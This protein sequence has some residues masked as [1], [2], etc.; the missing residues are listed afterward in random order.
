MGTAPGRSLTNRARHNELSNRQWNRDG[1][2]EI[3]PVRENTN[4]PLLPCANRNRDVAGAYPP[5][6]VGDQSEK[7]VPQE[8]FYTTNIT[9]GRNAFDSAAKT[10]VADVVAGS[11]V[12]FRCSEKNT[13]S[14]GSFWHPG[15]AMI[16]LSRAPDDD[17]KKYRGDGDWFKVAYAGPANNTK[18]SLWNA[19]DVSS[20]AE[21][22]DCMA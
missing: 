2:V 6:Y 16:Y 10:E 7:V 18:W 3:C 15:P 14:P 21:T 12:G 4:T 17:V 1:R 22:I 13:S 20:T 19:K 9:C 5:N 11:T 8:D